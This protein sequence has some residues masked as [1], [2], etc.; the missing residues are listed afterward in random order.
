[1]RRCSLGMALTLLAGCS[2]RLIVENDTADVVEVDV[3]ADRAPRPF[4]LRKLPSSLAFDTKMCSDE[5]MTIYVRRADERSP[6]KLSP[7]NFC[8]A[9]ACGCIIK[10]S[11]VS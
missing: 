11:N 10:V 6:R 1:M 5:A 3:V 4:H 2:P 7:S 8:A 9:Q